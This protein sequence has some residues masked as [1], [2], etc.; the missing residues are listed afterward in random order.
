MRGA[1][2]AA[3]DRELQ[4][5]ELGS[6]IV[7]RGR[8][9]SEAAE[10]AEECKTKSKAKEACGLDARAAT[11]LEFAFFCCCSTSFFPAFLFIFA[12]LFSSSYLAG[13]M[14]SRR[15]LLKS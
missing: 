6:A 5:D 14:V 7:M 2:R 15:K 12:W 13:L 4:T 9:S 10:L 1:G 3:L 11:Y 8:M